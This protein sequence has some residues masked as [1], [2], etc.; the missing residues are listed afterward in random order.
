MT[1]DD[2]KITAESID[3]GSLKND[4]S[5]KKPT[6]SHMLGE[7]TWL[8]SQSPL[9]KHFAVGDLEWMVM[10]AILLEQFRVFHGEKSPVGFALWANLSENAEQRLNDMAMA[11]QGARLRPDE[12]KS[13]ERLWL[14]EL[15][16]PFATAENKLI[17]SMVADLSQNVFPDRVIKMHVTDP[18]T[19]KREIKELKGAS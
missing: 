10:P 18:L 2:H 6:V 13:G 12:W 1:K 9:H 5:A 16:A 8:M 11:G 4:A 19:G 3:E 7:V 15:V 17:E 14:V